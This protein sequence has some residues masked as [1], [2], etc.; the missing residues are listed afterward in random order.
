NGRS[1]QR[2]NLLERI[3]WLRYILPPALVVV[4]V[5][6]QLGVAQWLSERYG[7]TVHYAFEIAF[8]SLTGPVITWLTLA[9][10]ERSLREKE[11]LE[12]EVRAR[13]QQLASL[14]EASAD[15]ILSLDNTGR[16]VSW[17]RGA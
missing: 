10:V 9:W 4:V 3:R 15:A 6:Y 5:F 13:T 14:T 16:I 1:W 11:A 12:R 8:Y 7:H 17:N 2:L